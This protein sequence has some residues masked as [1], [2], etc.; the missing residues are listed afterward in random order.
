MHSAEEIFKNFF[1]GRNP[2]QNFYDDDEDDIFGGGFHGMGM[3]M[4]GMGG[5]R[6]GMSMNQN[7]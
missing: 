1:G 4:G 5:M 6:M 3:G 7:N 2:F